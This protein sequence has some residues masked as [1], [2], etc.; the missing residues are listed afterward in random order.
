MSDFA[1]T[2][3]YIVK[4]KVL[5]IMDV[6]IYVLRLK[7]AVCKNNPEFTGLYVNTS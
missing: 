3:F 6:L 7:L 2:L 4:V 1:P 5:Y